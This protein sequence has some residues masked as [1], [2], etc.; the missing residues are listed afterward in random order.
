MSHLSAC[1][2]SLAHPVSRDKMTTSSHFDEAPAT[3]LELPTVRSR[4]WLQRADQLN[5]VFDLF[6]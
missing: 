4:C 1:N 2:R 6:L 3:D 5:E